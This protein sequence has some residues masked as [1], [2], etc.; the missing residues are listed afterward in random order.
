MTTR[1]HQKAP[2]AALTAKQRRFVGEYLIDLSA[3]KAAIRAGYSAKTAHSAGPRLLEH[4][5]VA[6][7]IDEAMAQR[8]ERTRITAD[9]VLRELARIAFSDIRALFDE[10]GA[11]RNVADL[12]DDEAAALAA[13]EVSEI[14]EGRGEDREHVGYLKKVK[15]WDKKGALELAMRHLGLLKE[16]VEHSGEMK[17]TREI[18]HVHRSDVQSSEELASE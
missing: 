4:V 18:V 8:A 9:R 14:F 6:K 3:T 12:S 15:L 5:G 11:L 13:V 1:K 17:I 10:K 2:S 16:R 7:A